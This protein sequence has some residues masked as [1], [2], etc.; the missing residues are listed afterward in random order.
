MPGEPYLPLLEGPIDVETALGHDDNIL[1]QLRYPAQQKQFRSSLAAHKADIEAI[2][3]YQLGVDW[4]HLCVPET[5][6]SGSFNVVIP[7]L[8]RHNKRVFIRLPLPYKIGEE[9]VPGN[10]EE[11]LRTEIA[12][13]IWLEE[14]CPDVPIT[15]LHGFGLPGG[16]TVCCL[17]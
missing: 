2:I 9:N 6:R 3:R 12:T 4:C 1:A 10:T 8:L 14:R 16:L 5:W 11:K 15:K 7:I 13:Y 17:G